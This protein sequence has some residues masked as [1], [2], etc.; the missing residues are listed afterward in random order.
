MTNPNVD[1][2]IQS[3]ENGTALFRAIEGGAIPREAE[4]VIRL[5]LTR[6][7]LDINLRDNSGQTALTRAL[8]CGLAEIATLLRERGAV[9]HDHYNI[10]DF[11]VLF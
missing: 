1:V 10:E 8:C 4:D 3:F 11:D 6:D 5:L 7:D 9:E 2:N